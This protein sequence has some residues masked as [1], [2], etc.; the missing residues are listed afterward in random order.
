MIGRYR[1]SYKKIRNGY[2]NGNVTSFE[3]FFQDYNNKLLRD[4]KYQWQVLTGEDIEDVVQDSWIDFIKR[5]SK[6]KPIDNDSYPYAYLR[7]IAN[8]NA[9]D[10]SENRK[11]LKQY[12][13]EILNILKSE[14]DVPIKLL[15]VLEVPNSKLYKLF[16]KL[17]CRCRYFLIARFRLI[18]RQYIKELEE[19]KA[20]QIETCKKLIAD[21]KEPLPPSDMNDE[22]YDILTERDI[23]KITEG[24]INQVKKR[25]LDNLQKILLEEVVDKFRKQ[26]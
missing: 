11:K 15:S 5:F 19:I 10:L 3:E 6:D 2:L 23:F 1:H 13:E 18:T 4:I 20:N 17:S 7:E 8:N 24:N 9:Y 22:D 16:K 26:S 25:C 12:I 14:K 21:L